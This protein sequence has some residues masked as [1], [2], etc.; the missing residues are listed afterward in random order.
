MT[1][2]EPEPPSLADL[3]AKLDA[4][5]A[6]ED[7]ETGRTRPEGARSGA[8]LGFRI[9]VELVV[10]IAVGAGLGY[11]LDRALQS[12]PWFMLVFF[13]LGAAAGVLNVYRAAKSLSTG[14]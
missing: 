1:Y 6:R 9:A 7:T 8:G 11:A 14:E 10:G 13:C 5:R 3:G 2:Q 12:R 4:A